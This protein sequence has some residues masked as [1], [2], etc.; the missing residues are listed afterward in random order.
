MPQA[1]TEGRT[2]TERKP[3]PWWH[4]LRE[5]TAAELMRLGYENR[6]DL[7][8]FHAKPRIVNPSPNGRNMVYD[9]RHFAQPWLNDG[10][11]KKITLAMFNEVRSWLGDSSK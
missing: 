2:M 6:E 3:R 8:V 5:E 7:R 10:I 11:P 1:K 9:P 4:G